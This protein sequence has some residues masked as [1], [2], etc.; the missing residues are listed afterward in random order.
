MSGS[1]PN[2]PVI[3]VASAAAGPV[4]RAVLAGIE[5][6]GVPFVVERVA[7]GDAV[8]L[9]RTAALRS[10]L[11]VGVGIDVS[12]GVCVQPEKVADPVPELV[13]LPTA[14]ARTGRTLGHDA[15]RICV[16]LPLKGAAGG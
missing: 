2:R 9:A 4:E 5:E 7:D 12:G 15:A 10:P 14:G 3:V 8:E 6:E 1:G 13:A 11:G 16:G